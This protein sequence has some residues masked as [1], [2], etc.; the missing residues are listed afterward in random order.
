MRGQDPPTSNS[1][2]ARSS[3]WMTA[4]PAP[5]AW[6]SVVRV[7]ERRDVSDTSSVTMGQPRAC[8]RRYGSSFTAPRSLAFEPRGRVWKRVFQ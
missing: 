4:R 3:S 1:T 5:R 8:Q 2:A 7:T 6:R